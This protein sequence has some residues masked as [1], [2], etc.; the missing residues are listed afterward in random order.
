MRTLTFFN[1]I[2]LSAICFFAAFSAHAEGAGWASPLSGFVLREATQFSP[3]A[4]NPS[5][6]LAPPFTRPAG[7]GLVILGRRITSN[8]GDLL[9]IGMDADPR[10]GLPSDFWVRAADLPLEIL[11]PYSAGAENE[12]G[13]LKAMTYCY[14]FVK[15][16][17]MKTGKVSNYL[18]GESAWMAASILPRY[19]FHRTGHSPANAANGEVCVYSGGP[20][21]HGHI[22]V[23]RGGAWWYGYGMISHSMQGR[24][25]IACF[26]K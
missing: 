13:A 23:K 10:E 9:R 22:E 11:E 5:A 12:V 14:R 18:P 26:Y 1:G 2:I 25:F 17:L 16:Y 7:T 19:G 8:D 4:A 24:N 20:Q 6:I 15:E 3:V 21:G